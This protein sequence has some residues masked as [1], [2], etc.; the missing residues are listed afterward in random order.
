MQAEELVSRE[1]AKELHGVRLWGKKKKR[2]K[3]RYFKTVVHD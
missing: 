3:R 1:K 2:N